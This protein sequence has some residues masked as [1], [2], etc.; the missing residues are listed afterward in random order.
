M[1]HLTPQEI[2]KELDKY[3]VGQ[4]EAKKCSY[5]LRNSIKE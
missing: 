2:V 4:E 5:C 1:E 3:I